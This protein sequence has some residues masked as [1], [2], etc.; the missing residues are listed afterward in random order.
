MFFL[1]GVL[2]LSN[3]VQGA[4]VLDVILFGAFE[5][6]L[7]LLAVVVLSQMI[8]AHVFERIWNIDHTCNVDQV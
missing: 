1:A 4:V 7:L 3:A 2:S 8:G 5:S 6:H